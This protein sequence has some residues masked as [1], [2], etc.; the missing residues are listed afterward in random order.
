MLI[1]K[2]IYIFKKEKK[3]NFIN[4]HIFKKEITLKGRYLKQITL[5]L[6]SKINKKFHYFPSHLESL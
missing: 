2:Y 4:F 5:F 1:S 3:D 6:Q